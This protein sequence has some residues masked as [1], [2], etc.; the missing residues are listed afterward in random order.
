MKD[1]KN[2]SPPLKQQMAWANSPTLP[3]PPKGH[4]LQKI[5][6]GAREGT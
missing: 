4:P 2:S 1:A 6:V 5:T 3:L